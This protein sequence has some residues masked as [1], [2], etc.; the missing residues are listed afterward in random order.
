VVLPVD[1]SRP[2]PGEA[3]VHRA[4]ALLVI[5]VWSP[6]SDYD[7]RDKIAGYMHRG[8]A[9]IWLVQPAGRTLSRWVR[10]PDGQYDES[11]AAGPL[12]P[13]ALPGV[14]VDV[15]TLLAR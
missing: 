7:Q 12:A 13:A 15:V 10:R 5:E 1:R 9:E 8:D 4:P 14:S 11:S 2:D 6:D 3:D